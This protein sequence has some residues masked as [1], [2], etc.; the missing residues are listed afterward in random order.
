MLNRHHQLVVLG[1][2]YRATGDRRFARGAVNQ[3][4]SWFDACPYGMGLNWQ[5]PTEQ[6]IRPDQLGLRLRADR[7]TGRV[8]KSSSTN[9]SCEAYICISMTF[10]AITGGHRAPPAT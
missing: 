7:W 9:G 4:M 2:A 1:R 6:A 8:W 10:P 3:W 5:R